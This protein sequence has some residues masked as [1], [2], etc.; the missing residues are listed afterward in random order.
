MQ[1]QTLTQL[2]PRLGGFGKDISKAG[3]FQTAI[4]MAGLDWNVAPGPVQ[5]MVG[6][7]IVEVPDF[8][9]IVRTD[10]LA[11]LGIVGA[12]YQP[13][14]NRDALAIV[15]DFVN[16][17]GCK[18]IRAGTF[19]GGAA[20]FFSLELPGRMKIG[21]T[22]DE[23]AKFLTI[24]NSHDGSQMYRSLF[25]PFRLYCSNQIRA[26]MNRFRESVAI[27]HTV[28]GM[29]K[30]NEARKSLGAANSYYSQFEILADKMARTPFSD[31]QMKE[32]AATVFPN[33]VD[34][35]GETKELSGRTESNRE[36]VV[37]LFTQGRGH[38]ESGIVGT[39]WA[40]L[41]AVVEFV[42]YER[43]TRT[44]NDAT[45]ESTRATSAWFGSGVAM[46]AQA[47]QTVMQMTRI[48]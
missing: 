1:K 44:F 11:P 47:F 38:Q 2:G 20:T 19:N 41:N 13:F 16:E 40:G 17:G 30:L 15:E 3:D 43:G 27:R 12:K 5:T 29:N 26:V 33:K 32:L 42:D 7:R 39:A 35:S 34:E 14:Q 31:N 22:G 8:K 46:K 37:E 24:I 36:K 45:A 4:S 6:D 10:T 21:P 25:S 18:M 9:T 28:K 48:A 23:V